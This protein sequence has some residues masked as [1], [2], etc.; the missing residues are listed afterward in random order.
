MAVPFR[1]PAKQQA[2]VT[3]QVKLKDRIAAHAAY[4]MEEVM[5]GAIDFIMSHWRLT[6][7]Y[8]DPSL[9]GMD[10]VM[11]KFYRSVLGAAY[12]SAKEEKTTQ[13]PVKR[14]AK[15]KAPP[16]L[17]EKL[18]DVFR[19]RKY[20]VRI[21]KRSKALTESL[22][23]QY[24]R[25]L[26]FQFSKI[27]PMLTAGEV[28]PEQV[29]QALRQKWVASKARVETIF[30]TES[31]AYFAEAQVSFFKDDDEIIGFLFDSVSDSS[32]TNICR[33]RHGLVYR[34]D[35]EQ[36]K[37]NIPPCHFNCRSH[38]IALANTPYNQKLLAD[39]ARDPSRRKVAPLPPGWRS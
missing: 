15:V 29:K 5:E 21:M 35:T 6:G 26:K 30:R 20:W 11:L 4:Q 36:L 8:M 34:P 39:P 25:K 28:S 1:L 10:E 22:R 14:L 7:R 33:S 13:H 31:T 32:T 17:P 38:L 23:K 27:L 18:E 16:A 2:Q 12:H 19:N 24:R 37:R 9:V 3:R